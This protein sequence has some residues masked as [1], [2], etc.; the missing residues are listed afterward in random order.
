MWN[1]VLL[2]LHPEK[3]LPQQTLSIATEAPISNIPFKED[4]I[5]KAYFGQVYS[6]N[7]LAKKGI[8][9]YT[10]NPY[11]QIIKSLIFCIQEARPKGLYIIIFEYFKQH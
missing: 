6:V 3:P 8:Q 4:I 1:D 10:I 5:L 7:L 9:H 2:V 11:V